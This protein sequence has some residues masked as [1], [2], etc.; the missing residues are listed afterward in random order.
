MG[1]KF[2]SRWVPKPQKHGYSLIP[3]D[4]SGITELGNYV[5]LAG[6][7]GVVGHIRIGDQVI[8]G[9]QSGV[10]KDV[11]SKKMMSG[12]PV[13]DHREWLKAQA[14]FSML[15]EMKKRLVSL[16]KQVKELKKDQGRGN[17]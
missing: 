11:S 12:T 15:P 8:I 2:R 4:I 6:Q 13:M 3:E 7:V 10:I 16:E 17:D 1:K 9:A 5:T 14:V